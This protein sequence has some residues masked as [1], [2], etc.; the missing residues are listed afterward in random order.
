MFKNH[1]TSLVFIIFGLTSWLLSLWLRNHSNLVEQFYSRGV[2]QG[3]RFV[4]DYTLGYLPFASFYIFWIGIILYWFILIKT[5]PKIHVFWNR[6]GFWSIKILSFIGL[7]LGIFYWV[8]GYNYQRKSVV[9]MINLNPMPLDTAA[10]WDE[11]RIETKICDSLRNILMKTDTNAMNDERF[12][13]KKTEDT[14]RL[15]VQ[16]WLFQNNYPAK[17]K[18]RGRILYPKGLLLGFGAA[19]LYWPFI[20]EGNIDAGLHPLQKLPTMAHEMSHGYGFGDEGIC[21]FIAYAACYQHPNPYISYSNRLSYW[22]T[23]AANCKKSDPKRYQSTFYPFIP[24]GIRQDVRAI[25]RQMDKYD[26]FFPKIRYQVYDSYLKSQGIGVG[27]LNYEEVI[28]L[29]RSMRK[30]EY[31]KHLK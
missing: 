19:G 30:K 11:L 20:G 17:S 7:I 15:C 18:V 24:A 9:E 25:Q 22:R 21:N 5:S 16:N 1:K 26:E 4:F 29:V 10:L 27:M 31:S 3:I 2:Y 12:F 6:I 23:V 8:W 14:V 13:F 28:M